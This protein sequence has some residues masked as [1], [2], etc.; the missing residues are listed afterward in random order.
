MD[1]AY[2]VL[3]QTDDGQVERLHRTDRQLVDRQVI[4]L[5]TG[6]QVV[7]RRIVTQPSHQGPGVVE[8]EPFRAVHG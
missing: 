8:T 2:R 3:I 5:D 4:R 7:V 1:F 6:E